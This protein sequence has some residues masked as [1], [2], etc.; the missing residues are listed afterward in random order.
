MVKLLRSRATSPSSTRWPTEGGVKPPVREH[1]PGGCLLYSAI[2]LSKR[3]KL[4]R[5]R[6]SPRNDSTAVLVHLVGF[7]V[8]LRRD[9]FVQP[10][11]YELDCTV[12]F[13]GD[14]GPAYFPNHVPEMLSSWN[15]SR[16][17]VVVRAMD[18]L[19]QAQASY[20][21]V[22]PFPW[23]IK[24]QRVRVSRIKPADRSGADSTEHSPFF[25]SDLRHRPTFK[26]RHR[27][28]RGSVFP[29]PT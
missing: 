10:A 17:A 25:V 9:H 19:Y 29:P 3:R 4:F 18:S 7:R 16:P 14:P 8:F 11:V 24:S 20:I 26:R 1:A 28:I 13:D 27:R 2:R 23:V 15:P 21:Y 22:F 5:L 6:Y 12:V